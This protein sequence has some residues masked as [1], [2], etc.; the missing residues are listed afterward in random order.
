MLVDD[1]LMAK[2]GRVRRLRNRIHTSVI[3][4]LSAVT[5]A[6]LPVTLTFTFLKTRRLIT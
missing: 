3:E 2:R 4:D 1:Y 6:T 5:Q